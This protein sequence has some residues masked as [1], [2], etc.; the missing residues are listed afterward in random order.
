MRK[1]IILS[2]SILIMNTV[3]RAQFVPFTPQEYKPV[4]TDVSILQRSLE[5]LEARENEAYNQYSQLQKELSEYSLKLNND[6]QTLLWF[7][8]YKNDI[9]E[10]FKQ[11]LRYGDYEMA[12]EYGIRKR[13]EI[14]NDS[15]LIARIRTS[16]EYQDK[17]QSIRLSSD[18]T[19]EEKNQWEINN[20][21]CFVPFYGSDGKVIGGRLGSKSELDQQ[22]QEAERKK[23]EAERL[24]KIE[25]ENEKARLYKMEHPFDDF[26]YSGYEKVIEYPLCKSTPDGM[27][28]TKV[29]LSQYETRVE[30]RLS[31]TVG[32][33]QYPY[34]AWC[35]IDRQAY[36][37]ASNS[38]KLYLIKAD[39]IAMSPSITQFKGPGEVL[40][41]ALTFPPLPSNAKSFTLSESSK[42]GWKF[43][44]IKLNK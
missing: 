24:A 17:L 14:A 19:Q 10:T 34:V 21:Y 23:Q 25:A 27:L 26:D 20:P 36:I 22:R 16:K 6:E 44:D 42:D 38:Q 5:R 4:E 29:A 31:N 40:M 18:M 12:I 32:L 43:K 15:E 41:F 28:V 11:I 3:M 39:N 13:G 30:I 33:Y 7:D 8:K 37:K 2:L 9:T 35:C 1:T